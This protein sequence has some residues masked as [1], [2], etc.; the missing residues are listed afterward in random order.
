MKPSLWPPGP[1]KGKTVSPSTP[2]QAIRDFYTLG[3]T[4][5]FICTCT[6]YS[7]CIFKPHRQPAYLTPLMGWCRQMKPF[8]PRAHSHCSHMRVYWGLAPILPSK[9]TWWQHALLPNSCNVSY[10]NPSRPERHW[11][12]HTSCHSFHHTCTDHWVWQNSCSNKDLLS[13]VSQATWLQ[14]HTVRSDVSTGP[15]LSWDLPSIFCCKL[16][17]RD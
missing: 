14:T 11:Q 10:P 17:S 5:V 1:P 8:S 16:Y 2:S 13:V 6:S 12:S 4:N 3:A 9:P 15:R 7:R